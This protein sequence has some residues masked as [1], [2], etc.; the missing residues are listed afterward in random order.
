MKLKIKIGKGNYSV[1]TFDRNNNEIFY[2]STRLQN[3]I[4]NDTLNCDVPEESISYL[5]KSIPGN[6][7][8]S[9]GEITK[10]KEEKNVPDKRE[11]L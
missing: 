11:K 3:I 10:I 1:R 4:E 9:K 7:I 2:T 6:K 5:I 8:V